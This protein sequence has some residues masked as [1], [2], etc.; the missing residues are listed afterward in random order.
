MYLC[1]YVCMYM[2]VCNYMFIY[3]MYCMFLCIYMHICM[4][5]CCMYAYT[6]VSR[7]IYVSGS[8]PALSE[9]S[10]NFS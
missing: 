8:Y 4:Y 3:V 2:Y 5:V 9:L 6:H 1:I 10:A 7:Y